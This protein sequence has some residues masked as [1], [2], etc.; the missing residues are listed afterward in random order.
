MDNKRLRTHII[1]A[2]FNLRNIYHVV[3]C[4]SAS[5]LGMEMD[6]SLR[7]PSSFC[8]PP[9]SKTT[10]IITEKKRVDA[11]GVPD[12][13]DQS[14]FDSDEEDWDDVLHPKEKKVQMKREVE[15]VE[16]GSLDEV[17]ETLES[18]NEVD[19]SFNSAP[20]G[21]CDEFKRWV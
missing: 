1:Q 15:K 2:D 17:E 6:L 13:T 14:S 7:P 10:E 19:T 11:L 18:C 4:Q 12:F 16:E 9:W 3:P 5:S 8:L 20:A 21:N